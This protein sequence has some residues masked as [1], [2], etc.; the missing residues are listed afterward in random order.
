MYEWLT[1][2]TPIDETNDTLV[3]LEANGWSYVCGHADANPKP[4]G[5]AHIH[6][7]LRRHKDK[8]QN[9]EK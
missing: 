7:I 9:E 5:S 6:L 3:R 1:I 2:V 4:D 8:I